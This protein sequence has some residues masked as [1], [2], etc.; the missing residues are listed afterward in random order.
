MTIPSIQLLVARWYP[1]GPVS[2][3]EARDELRRRGWSRLR[4]LFAIAALLLIIAPD[5]IMHFLDPA[6]DD[7][8]ETGTPREV[9]FGALFSLSMVSLVCALVSAWLV[10][11]RHDS[12]QPYQWR[13]LIGWASLSFIAGYLARSVARQRA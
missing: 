2:A 7:Q 5:R 12:G 13:W 11:A 1:G 10:I 6:R 9:A 8:E 3:S 4:Q